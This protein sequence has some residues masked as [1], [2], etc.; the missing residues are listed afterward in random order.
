MFDSSVYW[1]SIS[2]KLSELKTQFPN[3]FCRVAATRNGQVSEVSLSNAARCIADGTHRLASDDEIKD[4]ERGMELR[5]A[6]QA[7]SGGGLEAA[8]RMFQALQP[9]RKDAK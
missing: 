8:R 3:G 5:K 2:T 6:Q 7:Q 4:F 1:N 9:A